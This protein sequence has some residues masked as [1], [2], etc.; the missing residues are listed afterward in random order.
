MSTTWADVEYEQGMDQIRE[1]LKH[2]ED[3]I[4]ELKEGLRSDF[5][6]ER[7]QSYYF[8]EGKGLLRPPRD[9]LK[10][11]Q[12]LLSIDPTASFV[13]AV[14]AIELVIRSVLLKPMVF[15]LVHEKVA[16]ELAD[17]ILRQSRGTDG[18]SLLDVMLAEFAGF[19]IRTYTRPGAKSNLLKEVQKVSRARDLILH[20]GLVAER[21][22]A[23]LAIGIAD[24]LFHSVLPRVLTSIGLARL[25]DATF[26]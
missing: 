26:C 25:A 8:A 12:S 13:F 23:E 2:D 4:E 17:R 14:A 6:L 7:L 5:D 10:R 21:H 16:E 24:D 15:G 18:H 19:N 1:D 11:S 3:F 9:A 20:Q 22:H